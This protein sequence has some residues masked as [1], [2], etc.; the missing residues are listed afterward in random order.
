M[1]LNEIREEMKAERAKFL[2]GTSD[3]ARMHEL[4]RM[5]ADAFNERARALAKA[6]GMKPRLTTPQRI[7]RQ[8]EFLR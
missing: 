1:T 5:A 7:L 4:A 8:S 2:N 6:R 3:G